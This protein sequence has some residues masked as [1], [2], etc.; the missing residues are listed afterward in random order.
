MLSGEMGE[1]GRHRIK[2]MKT[3]SLARKMGFQL[4]S[5]NEEK[6]DQINI[7]EIGWTI[8]IVIMNV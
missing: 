5:G 6:L 7:K 4:P 2:F 1:L 8:A 3:F